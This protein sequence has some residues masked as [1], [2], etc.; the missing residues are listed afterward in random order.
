MA[1]HMTP[2]SRQRRES[3]FRCRTVFPP[4]FAVFAGLFAAVRSKGLGES[5]TWQYCRL[6]TPFKNGE[7]GEN[8]GRIESTVLVLGRCQFSSVIRLEQ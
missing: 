8:G 4:F 2:A 6:E 1:Q 3:F 7:N 5:I